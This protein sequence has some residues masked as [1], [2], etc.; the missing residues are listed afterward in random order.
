LLS[1][2]KKYLKKRP[3]KDQILQ[4]LSFDQLL[5]THPEFTNCLKLVF[6]GSVRNTD[7]ESIVAHLKSKIDHLNLNDHVEIIENATYEI[8]N[9]Y[10]RDCAIGLHSM[11]NEH[12][13]IS[14][15]EYMAA[16]LITI[17][18]D[19]GGSLN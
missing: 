2:G 16:G 11:Y 3:E 6:I 13:G 1:S 12:F 17:A 9:E 8:L 14:I 10:L 15:V 5:K 18:N 19:S 7:D 4:I